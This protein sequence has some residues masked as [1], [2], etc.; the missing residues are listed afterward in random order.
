M[1]F[2]NQTLRLAWH[3]PIT[4]LT[5]ADADEA[6]PEEDEVCGY[7][8]LFFSGGVGLLIEC[9]GFLTHKP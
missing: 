9:E 2:N 4:A 5:T 6:E 3:K 7:F 8:S 1:K